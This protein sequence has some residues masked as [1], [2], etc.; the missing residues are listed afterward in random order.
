[1]PNIIERLKQGKSVENFKTEHIRKDGKRIDVSLTV[2]P[3]IDSKGQVMGASA[4]ARDITERKENEQAIE[5]LTEELRQRAFALEATTEELESFSY[6]VSHDLRAPLRGING[7]AQALLEDYAPDLDDEGKKYLQRVCAASRHMGKLIDDL[8]RLSRVTRR[9][10]R[11]ETVDLSALALSVAADLTHTD[12]QRNVDFVMTP[13]LVAE[14]DTGLLRIV[15]QNLIGNAWKFTARQPEPK[16]EFGLARENGR[17]SYFVR[18]N[19]AGFDMAHADKLF[20]PFQR[21]HSVPEFEGTGIGLATVQRIVRR[22]GGQV[23]ARA[24]LHRGATFYFTLPSGSNETATSS[25][26]IAT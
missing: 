14:G 5:H 26:S 16:I 17:S 9:E 8:L 20:G 23:W 10:I 1:M 7:F 12:P 2:S 22:H 4:I 13:G 19:G 25:E 24:E 21:L 15:L 18:D 3:I 11:R 6:S